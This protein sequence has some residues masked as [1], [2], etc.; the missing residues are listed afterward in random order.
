MHMPR[1]Q[2]L[3]EQNIISQIANKTK[4]MGGFMNGQ[5][6]VKRILTMLLVCF[7]S[8]LLLAAST[9][10][11]DWP[12]FR[13]P[14]SNSGASSE[15]INLP[16]VEQWH[17]QAPDI[18]ENGVVVADGIAYITTDDGELHAFNVATGFN[19]PGFPITIPRS[20][21]TPAVDPANDR[22]YVLTS[23]TLYAIQLDGTTAWT[24]AVGSTGTNYSQGP[25]TEDGFVYFKAGVSLHK[26]NA[27]GTLQW[28]SPA[29]GPN[30]QPAIMGD[31]V[32]VNTTVG[33]I[34]RFNKATGV[35]D[36]SGNY[37]ILVGAT[38]ESSL[39]AINGKLFFKSNLLYAYNAADGSLVWSQPAGGNGTYS[40]SPAVSGGVVYVYGYDGKLYAFNENT[41]VTM[42][43]FP[44]ALLGA[45]ANDRNWSSPAVAGDK[46]FVAAGTTQKLKVVGAA[47]T[48]MAGQVLEE[49]L[50]FSTDPQGFDLCSP[51][52]SDCY[53]FAMLDGGGLYAYFGGC[54][55]PPQ[56]TLSINGGADCTESQMVTLTLGN[57]DDP[58]VVE[59]RISEDPFFSGVPW[60]P[61][62]ETSMFTL[63]PG[64]GSKTV[65]AQLKDNVGVLSNVFSATISY[66]E[67]CQVDEEVKCDVDGDGDI[68]KLDLRV[69]SRARNQPA[70]GPDD[71][72][73]ADGDGVITPRDVKACIPQCTLPGCAIQ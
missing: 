41:G 14:V 18:E 17:S 25:I 3:T 20:Y 53:V 4:K 63:S 64:F 49:H 15:T 21:S 28:M 24:R 30:T 72:R 68:D 47:G 36:L 59:M 26:Y 5:S 13:G 19:V 57:G 62:T 54:G 40:L 51:A 32:Y 7:S 43:G 66:Q 11:A 42:A 39:T 67:I 29:G 33:Q 35:E 8:F 38:Q 2:T 16:L 56:G 23:G 27:A 37:P 52:I 50:A 65:F 44:T 58:N 61:Y 10:A 71:P 48:A 34:R 46:V 6:M 55:E 12:N 1:K 70:S 22:V 31:Y 60:V 73:D 69:I 9:S 45:G